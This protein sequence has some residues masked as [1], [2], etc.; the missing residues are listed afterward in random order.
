MGR[1]DYSTDVETADESFDASE[2]I[3]V[4]SASYELPTHHTRK[5]DDAAATAPPST[6][7]INISGLNRRLRT[8]FIDVDPAD[9]SFSASLTRGIVGIV[10][11]CFTPRQILVALRLLKSITVC[12]LTLTMAAN[13]TYI[14]L[15]E[16]VSG[17]Y[18]S[19]PYFGAR[20]DT[21][22]R[23]YG[24]LLSVLA[25]LIELDK[26]VKAFKVWKGFIARF[27]LLFFV[28]VVTYCHPAEWGN[29]YY[30]GGTVPQSAVMFQMVVSSVLAICSFTYLL[31]GLL[32]FDRFTSRAFLSTQDPVA[33]TAIP[34]QSDYQSP[35]L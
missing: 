25:L 33:S 19:N 34:S 14:C 24:L 23:V 8:E 12:F 1:S 28:S 7:S 9:E 15:V 11:A 26:Y 5:K 2:S 31:F 35:R 20:R 32:C 21:V 10:G 4:E 16:F 6:K 27:A 13:V 3:P 18:S 22:L 29:G 30:G 17:A